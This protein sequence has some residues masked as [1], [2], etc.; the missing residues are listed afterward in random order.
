MKD[1]DMAIPNDIVHIINEYSKPIYRKPPHSKIIKEYMRSVRRFDT[2][3]FTSSELNYYGFIPL[4][5]CGSNGRRIHID[6]EG[7]YENIEY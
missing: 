7:F 4:N 1:S 2:S 6:Y 5:K 3:S